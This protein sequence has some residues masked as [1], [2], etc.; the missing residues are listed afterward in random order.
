MPSL[1][2]EPE[3]LILKRIIIK[4]LCQLISRL[5]LVHRVQKLRQLVDLRIL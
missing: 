5:L 3:L 1:K 2:V 4:T